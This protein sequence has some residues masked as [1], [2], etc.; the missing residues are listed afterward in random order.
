MFFFFLLEAVMEAQRYNAQLNGANKAQTGLPNLQTKI[1]AFDSEFQITCE[2]LWIFAQTW[3][4]VC[5]S[6]S[7]YRN[8]LTQVVQIHAEAKRYA[9]QLKA[10]DNVNDLPAVRL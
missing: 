7:P 1:V 2:A 5:N 3:D 4:Y 10:V 8:F 9:D 6:L